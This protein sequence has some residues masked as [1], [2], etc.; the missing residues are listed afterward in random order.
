MMNK[1]MKDFFAYLHFVVEDTDCFDDQ[2]TGCMRVSRESKRGMID[3]PLRV[4]E[5]NGAYVLVEGTDEEEKPPVVYL[6][7]IDLINGVLE[8]VNRRQDYEGELPVL[9]PEHNFHR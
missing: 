6:R 4:Y 9:Q 2:D 5:S 8:S 7:D 3:Y 1:P